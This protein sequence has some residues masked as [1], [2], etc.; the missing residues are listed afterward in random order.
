M[1]ESKA[2]RVRRSL[3]EAAVDL[4]AAEG[5]SAVQARRLAREIGA[6]TMA[7]YHYFGGMP[8]LLRAV[9]DEGFRELSA[10]LAD[11]AVTDDPIADIT[12]LA[13]AYRGFAHA[14][15]H[16]YDLMFGLAAPGGY[17]PAPSPPGEGPSAPGEG[18][19]AEEGGSTAERQDV[20]RAY[21]HLVGA[22]ERAVDA[23]RIRPADPD[24]VAAQLWSILH[25]Y[26]TLEL[27]G[28]FH[29]FGDA[30]NQVLLAMGENLLRGLGDDPERIAASAAAH[31]PRA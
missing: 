11:V 20:P 22:A 28:H 6:S 17:R 10:R 23:G 12:S 24:R 16:L 8:Q 31:R 30:A 15:P 25:G 7:V 2:D 29:Q 27:S 13:F 5:P 26:V 4:L 18:G 21:L 19:P 1:T 3:V 9:A 14:N